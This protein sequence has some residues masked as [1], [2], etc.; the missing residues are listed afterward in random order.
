LPLGSVRVTYIMF[1]CTGG[2]CPEI[3]VPRFEANLTHPFISKVNNYLSI[4]SLR[5]HG[6][7]LNQA[8]EH[9]SIS[10]YCTHLLYRHVFFEGVLNIVNRT[11]VYLHRY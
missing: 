5:R 3:K 11:V 2:Y 6:Q 10:L 9:F 1:T 8:Q 7:V 4:C